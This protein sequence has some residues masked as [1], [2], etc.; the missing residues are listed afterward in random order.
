MGLSGFCILVMVVRGPDV[1]RYTWFGWKRRAPEVVVQE[2]DNTSNTGGDV[3]PP[4][5][6]ESDARKVEA[7]EVSQRPALEPDVEKGQG[8]V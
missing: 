1:P 7:S 2:Q 3:E 5:R 4:Q 8:G 6:D